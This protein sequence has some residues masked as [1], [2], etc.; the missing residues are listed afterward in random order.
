MNKT[1][2]V[3]RKEASIALGV[4]VRTID[5]YV[6]AQ[7]L[8]SFREDGRIWLNK[9][10]IEGFVP[11][12][13]VVFMKNVDKSNINS[14]EVTSVD[15]MSTYSSETNSN[16]N[17]VE[18]EVDNMSRQVDNEKS[19]KIF[20]K[21][22]EDAKVELQIK[23]D[24]LEIATYKV[25][26]L[27]ARLKSSVPMLEYRKEIYEKDQKT[28]E[29]K[30]QILSQSSVL[31]KVVLDLKAQKFSKRVFVTILLILLALQP[32]WLLLLDSQ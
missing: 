24:R 29:M 1:H 25:G 4:S 15:T 28:Q 17:L 10:E 23:Q 27:E 30:E 3:S 20:K 12:K 19:S 16:S 9:D 6:K 22:Y 8:T 18:D 31:E 14:L 26:Q 13:T 2:T 5:R 32:L 7:K 21:L 11:R